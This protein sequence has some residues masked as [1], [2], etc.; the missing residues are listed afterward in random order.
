MKK[1]ILFTSIALLLSLDVISQSTPIPIDKNVKIG[2]LSNGLTYYIRKNAKPEARVELRLIV[3]AGSVLEKENQ[4]GV[5]HFLEHMAFNGTEHFP[6]N[7]LLSY[8]QKAGVRFG[9]DI[10]ATTSFDFTMYMLPLPTSNAT[11]LQNGYQ[12]LRDWA[13]GL[14]LESEEIDKERGV[15]LEEKRM[16]QNAGMRSFAKYLPTMTNNSMYGQ[17]IPI[18]KEDIIKTAPRKAFEDYYKAWY[19]PNNMALIAVGDIDID[20]AEAVIKSLF[21]DLRNPTNA[22][23]RPSIIPITWHQKNKATIVSDPE[24]TNSILTLHFGMEK[25]SPTTTWEAFGDDAVANVISELFGNRLQEYAANPKSP[26]S[27]G[28][29]DLNSDFFI[30]RG[31]K[32]ATIA[33]LVKNN[34]SEAL[35]MLIAE[36]LKARQFGFTQTEFERVKKNKLK[37]YEEAL[38]EKN[39]TESASFVN[40]YFEH[41]LKKVPTPGIE[42]EQKFIEKYLNEL[43]LE[44]VNKLVS[45]FDVNKPTYILF[46]AT[47][48][49]KNL[50]TEAGLINAFEKAKLQKIDAYVEKKLSTKLLDV[51]PTP[52]KVISSES[53]TDLDSKTLTLSNGIKVI[54]K[55]T[56]FKNDEI[57]FRGSQWGGQTNL[58]DEEIKVSKYYNL[59]GGLGLAKNKAADMSKILTGVNANANIAI[60]PNQLSMF[61]NASTNDFEKL[62]QILYLK[63]TNVNFDNEDFEGLKSNFSSQIGG[64]LKN[65]SFKFGDTLNQFRFNYHARVAGFPL[66]NELNEIQIDALKN[67]HQKITN[68]LNGTVLVF[69]GNIDDAIFNDLI[70][71]YIAAIPTQSKPVNLNK[72]MLLKPIK[73]KNAFTFKLGKENKSEISHSY[74][75]TVDEITD[76][77][78]LAFGLMSEILQM[79]ANEKLREEMGST[80]SPSVRGFILRSPINTFN[81][82]LAVSALPE[83][84]DKIVSAYDGLISNIINGTLSDEDLAKGKAQRLKVVETQRQT[85][86][87]WSLVLE[88]QFMYGFDAK[89]ITEFAKRIEAVTKDDITNVA[90]KYL[91]NNNVLKGVMNPE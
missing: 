29:I 1:N 4:Q 82:T 9:A 23:S 65:P 62:L 56:N 25:S 52:G 89:N 27:F 22:P 2:K 32:T 91:V 83:N 86:N 79:K 63:L 19:R 6:K 41:F 74:Y 26:I 88:Q 60:G 55:K 15:I 51:M 75:G 50:I 34:P 3:N 31:Y 30:F 80:Y 24:N 49:H 8:L 81:L 72:E 39:K 11:V 84:V 61:G 64:M 58:T 21:A 16:R 36:V 73:G 59:V 42:A 46:N 17:R 57:L 18:G 76:M 14:L 35:N 47:E 12:V 43:S 37:A 7:E 40:E 67:L 77:D 85:N 28:N 10:N 87:Y 48:A 5:A 69:V 20:K 66:A 70:E 78:N 44:K 45:K 33:G 38:K 68:N 13:G 90:K 54:Y 53:N 71:K